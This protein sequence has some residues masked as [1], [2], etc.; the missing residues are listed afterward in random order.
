MSIKVLHIIYGLTGGGAETQLINLVNYSDSSI[1]DNAIF[2]VDCKGQDRLNRNTKIYCYERKNFLDL[3]IYKSLKNSVKDFEPDIIHNWLPEYV[4]VPGMI[5]SKIYNKKCIFSFRNTMKLCNYKNIIEYIIAMFFSDAI[6][7]NTKY[8]FHDKY[9]KLLFNKKESYEI[10]NGFAI[11]QIR[12]N[13]NHDI[14]SIVKKFEPKKFNIIFVGRLTEQKNIM[15]LIEA[16]NLLCNKESYHLYI[17]GDGE[18]KNKL[19]QL[20]KNYNLCDEITFLGYTENI[21]AL[22]KAS[23]LLVLPSKYEGMPNVIFEAMCLGLPS[24]VSNIEQHKRWIVNN[25]NGYLFDI[26]DINDLANK[27]MKINY[28]KLNYNKV[29]DYIKH[30]I[31]D[32]N[33]NKM[34]N[35]Y[36]EC[37]MKIYHNSICLKK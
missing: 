11:D 8:D 35:K 13:S 9:Y 14:Y 17:C 1:I 26:N 18:Q 16:F 37:Y 25:E 2:C 34:A 3:G 15:S 4:T 23:D 6:I 10:N 32:F 5:I 27:I 21:Y 30:Y 36:A 22:M 33:V 19:T 28:D 7:S 29:K 12:K 20:V 31:E 24:L